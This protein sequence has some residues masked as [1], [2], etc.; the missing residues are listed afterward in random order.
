VVLLLDEGAETVAAVDAYEPVEAASACVLVAPSGVPSPAQLRERLAGLPRAGAVRVVPA[1]R[2]GLP[3]WPP[4]ADRI[5]S[6]LRRRRATGPYRNKHVNSNN[7]SGEG[8]A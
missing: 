7:V 5:V 3:P 6:G 4:K 1:G 2:A 8:I